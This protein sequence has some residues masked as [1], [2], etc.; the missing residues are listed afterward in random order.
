MTAACASYYASVDLL[1]TA[2]VTVSRAR[3]E[4]MWSGSVGESRVQEYGL[5]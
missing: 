1:L 4:G 5:V 2:R 3:S